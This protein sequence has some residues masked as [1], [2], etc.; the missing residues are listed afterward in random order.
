MEEVYSPLFNP[1][2]SNNTGEYNEEDL[3]HGPKWPNAPR[4]VF[5]VPCL[6][7]IFVKLTVCYIKSHA[8]LF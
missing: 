3:G 7:K 5:D 8:Y 1:T 4:N 2:T 6:P